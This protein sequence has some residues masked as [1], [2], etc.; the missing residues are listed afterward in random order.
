MR[1]LASPYSLNDLLNQSSRRMSAYLPGVLLLECVGI[2]LLFYVT[3][4]K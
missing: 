2:F 3:A 4:Q 1:R